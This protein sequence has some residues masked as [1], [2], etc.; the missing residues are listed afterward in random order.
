MTMIHVLDTNDLNSPSSSVWQ[1]MPSSQ[2][3]SR[4]K[5]ALNASNKIKDNDKV[6]QKCPIL[7]MAITICQRH[8]A[9]QRNNDTR[10]KL[11]HT[12]LWALLL[13]LHGWLLGGPLPLHSPTPKNACCCDVFYNAQWAPHLKKYQIFSKHAQ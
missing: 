4:G 2:G 11:Q 3:S 8:E 1:S 10:R 9:T 12:Q 7:M 13:L 6:L 5:A